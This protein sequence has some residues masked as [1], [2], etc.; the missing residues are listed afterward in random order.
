MPVHDELHEVDEK[1]DDAHDRCKTCTEQTSAIP[2]TR[3]FDDLRS[4]R[5]VQKCEDTHTHDDRQIRVDRFEVQ[6]EDIHH[7]VDGENG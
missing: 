6:V 5:I 3:P 2:P 4:E 7:R 1:N